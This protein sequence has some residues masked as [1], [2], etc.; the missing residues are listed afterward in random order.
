V[1]ACAAAVAAY[2]V[3]SKVF[4]PQY[5]IWL[6]PLVPLVRGR[7][8]AQ[9]SALLLAILGVTQIFEPYHYDDYWQLSTPWVIWAV[10][11]RNLLVVG[12]LA[13]LVRRIEPAQAGGYTRAPERP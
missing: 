6:T 8:G 5:L 3:F 7:R 11:V 12:L 1:I 13:L 9:A 4:S 10:V 2:I